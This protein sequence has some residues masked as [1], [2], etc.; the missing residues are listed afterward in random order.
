MS[1]YSGYVVRFENVS[2]E[3]AAQVIQVLKPCLAVLDHFDSRKPA[4]VIIEELMP[5]IGSEEDRFLIDV[6]Y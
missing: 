2:G 5:F 3:K 1:E 6:H 4:D